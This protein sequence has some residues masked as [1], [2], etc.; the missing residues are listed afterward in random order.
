MTEKASAPRKKSCNNCS[1]AKVRCDLKKPKCTRCRN[2]DISCKYAYNGSV[3]D[4]STI[5]PTILYRTIPVVD[6]STCSPGEAET[7]NF[8]DVSLI[9]TLDDDRIRA[10][11][12]ESV[13]PS[14]EQTPKSY[15]PS[16]MVFL[17]S[18][19]RSWPGIF[20]FNE[21]LPPFIHWTQVV[22]TIPM[23]LSSCMT[24]SRTWMTQ[25]PG[26][27]S[28]VCDVIEQEM[29]KLIEQVCSELSFSI[30]LD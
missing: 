27:E 6:N 16:T 28:M 9:R 13:L 4:Q 22:G 21:A 30:A 2:R 18:I 19:M 12:L 3:D 23:S 15:Q 26:S 24:L 20:L 10:R 17:A 5:A 14:P 7:L 29:R 11:W 8:D 25:I 1:K